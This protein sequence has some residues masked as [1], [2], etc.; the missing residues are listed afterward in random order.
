MNKKLLATARF[1]F[2]QCVFM[3][4][5]HYKSYSRLEGLQ[6]RNRHIVLG[7]ASAT[8]IAIILQ[9]VGLE[10]QYDSLLRV[11]S[12]CG[13][14]LTG[15][16]LVFEIYNKEDISEIKCQHRNAA[17]EYKIKRDQFMSLIEE[18]MSSSRSEKELRKSF[19]RLQDSYSNIGKYSPTTTGS[20]YS[21][22]QTGLGLKEDSNEE[23]TWSSEE[24]DKFLP[25][26]L[27]IS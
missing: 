11:L 27:R 20:D 25:I 7:I 24:I 17:E 8:L 19:K 3:N 1:Y 5:I 18:I 22:A 26:T 10:L 13:M 14:I 9:I 15:A 6:N 2:A 16:G 21:N 12:F 4:N 23:F